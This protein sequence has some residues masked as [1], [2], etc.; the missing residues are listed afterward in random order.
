MVFGGA[1][2]HV[3]GRN[4]LHWAHDNLTDCRLRECG[5][6]VILT[7]HVPSQ[8]DQTPQRG[9]RMQLVREVALDI[10]TTQGEGCQCG[11]PL[12]TVTSAAAIFWRFSPPDSVVP[13][14]S[15]S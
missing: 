2:R 8:R 5:P 13:P 15:L 1:N 12:G 7:E 11:A 4:L 10:Q 6:A 3:L 9:D 14:P